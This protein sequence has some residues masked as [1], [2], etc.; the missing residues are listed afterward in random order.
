MH[1]QKPAQSFPFRLFKADRNRGSNEQALKR[2][3]LLSDNWKG[4]SIMAIDP[5]CGMT[6]DPATAAGQAAHGGQ[7]YYFCSTHCL[8]KF[9]ANPERYVEAGAPKQPSVP[10]SGGTTYTCPMHPEIRQD[11]PGVCPKCG[12]ALEPVDGA[13]SDGVST[14]ST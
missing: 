6:V 7:T 13:V 3:T 11:R 8:D 5:I 14:G 1:S 2:P 10:T 12:M 9:R 4:E